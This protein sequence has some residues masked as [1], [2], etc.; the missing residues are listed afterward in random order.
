MMTE[1]AGKRGRNVRRTVKRVQQS[2]Q[3][4]SC[5]TQSYQG[6]SEVGQASV[7][8]ALTIVMTLLLIFGLID[9]SRA[10]YTA[11]IIQWAAQSGARAAIIDDSQEAVDAAVKDR[12]FG[13][14][15]DA[16]VVA[17]PS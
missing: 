11:S 7:E 16:V 17:P 12:M 1:P 9:F 5:Q 8:F 13:L 15:K 10:I 3:T 14:D 4:Q 2:R 6:R